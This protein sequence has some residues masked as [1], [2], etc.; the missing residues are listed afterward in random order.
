MRLY[1]ENAPG[2]FPPNTS[3]LYATHL[4]ESGC[5][6]LVM[7]QDGQTVGAGGVSLK[8]DPAARL[9]C[10]LTFGLVAP[11]HHRLGL[12]TA[13]LLARIALLP[14]DRLPLP[15]FMTAVWRSRSFYEQFGFQLFCIQAVEQPPVVGYFA[16]T[17]PPGMADTS[18]RYLREAGVQ[19]P[20]TG[21]DI[22]VLH[23]L[24]AEQQPT[25]SL[26]HAGARWLGSAARKLLVAHLLP[27]DAS[28]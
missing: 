17:V 3:D 26:E 22:P 11:T 24:P 1:V 21:L 2:R 10:W 25:T 12:G 7:E 23:N 4:R 8:S 6:T 28:K 20:E 9:Y 27:A 13:L 5:L 16:A 18:R 14:A 19:M 15:A